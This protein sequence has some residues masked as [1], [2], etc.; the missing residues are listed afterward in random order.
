MTTP[1]IVTTEVVLLASDKAHDEA[2]V[3]EL[4]RIV[5]EAY[6]VGEDGLWQ[7]GTTRIEPRE[8]A[9]AIRDDGMLA[10]RLEGRLVGCAY[11]RPLDRGTADLGLV[12]TTP[13]RWGGGIGT[14]LV[15]A[16]EVLTRSR[17]VT[18]M[19][20]EVLVPKQGSH[21]AKERLRSWYTRLGYQVVR[22]APIDEVAPHLAAQLAKPC[23]F[24]IFHKSLAEPPDEGEQDG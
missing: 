7:E 13:D 19:Q 23:E 21:P 17:G 9:A 11:V 22:T 1:H 12:S 6:A 5:N 24:L 14:E 8:I 3:E 10:A 2:L 20:L 18:A 4:A 15:R 16:A